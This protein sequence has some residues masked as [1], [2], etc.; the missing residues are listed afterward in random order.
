[1][2]PPI[3]AL[4]VTLLITS[5]LASVRAQQPDPLAQIQQQSAA[6]HAAHDPLTRATHAFLLNQAADSYALSLNRISAPFAAS[7]TLTPQQ[8]R[9][10]TA[11][12]VDIANRFGA[13]L[14]WCEFNAAWTTSL[15]GY[16]LYLTLWPTGPLA[17]EAWWRGTLGQTPTQ[18]TDAEGSPEET[19]RLVHQYQQFLQHFPQ[20]AHHIEATRTLAEFQSEL[21]A[22]PSPRVP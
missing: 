2:S 19:L 18:C 3:P 14:Q 17:E 6:F 12:A 4:L 15:A 8:I 22:S 21:R 16:R 13:N 9:A 11:L 5:S 10:N 1:M 20:G 7:P